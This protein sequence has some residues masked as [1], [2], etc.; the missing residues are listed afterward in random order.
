MIELRKISKSFG[1][2]SAV[3]A[4]SMTIE[5]RDV[6]VVQGPSGSGKTT[7]LRLIA[8]LALPDDGEI[9]ID[10]EVV[11][12]PSGASPPFSR[13]VGVVF[14]RSALWPHMTVAQNIRFP[15]LNLPKQAASERVAQLLEAVGLKDLARRYPNQ[16]SGGEARRVALARALAARPQRLLLDEPLTHID[17]ALKERLLTLIKDQTQEMGATLMYITHDEREAEDVG[18]RLHRM[19]NGR[20]VG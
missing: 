18:G 1:V 9:L 12:T 17:P 3:D 11:S 10:E 6:V 7:L 4:A 19:E 5:A 8:G 14:Q 13:G 20:V 15:I 16:L 2:V